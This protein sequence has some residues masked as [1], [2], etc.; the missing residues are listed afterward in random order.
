MICCIKKTERNNTYK[1]MRKHFLPEI[2]V[3][4]YLKYPVKMHC[5]I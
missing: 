3:I 4:S 5:W 2:F 1:L